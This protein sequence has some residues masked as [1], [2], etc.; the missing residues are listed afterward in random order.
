MYILR[1]YCQNRYLRLSN[2][3]NS[4]DTEAL[5]NR[6]KQLLSNFS[7][8]DHPLVRAWTYALCNGSYIAL[9]LRRPN[10]QLEMTIMLATIIS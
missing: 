4:E 9:V 10:S 6:A 3:L 8:E 1:L 5:L 2:F 7:L